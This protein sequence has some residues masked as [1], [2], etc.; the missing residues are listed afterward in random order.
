MGINSP[1]ADEVSRASGEGYAHQAYAQSL[2]EFGALRELPRCGG[3]LLER[4]VPKGTCID[5]TGCY[6]LFS[7]RNWQVLGDDL[8]AL[9]ERLV[10]AS[11]VTDPFAEITEPELRA[12]FPNVCYPYKQH[13]VTDL[14]LPLDTIVQSHHRRN[15]RKALDS[16]KVQPMLSGDELLSLWLPL[17]EN[18]VLRH[19]VRG[20]ARFSP[21]SFARQMNVPG[22]MAFAAFDG[23][24]VCG[25]TLWYLSGDVAYYHLAAYSEVGYERG[26]SF[27]LFWTALTHF[28]QLGA[29]WAALGAGAGTNASESGLTRFKQG[30]ATGTR[31]VYFCGRILQPETYQRLTGENPNMISYFPAYRCP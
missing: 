14:S 16:V 20:I 24:D 17:Y 23:D 25:M 8:E 22:F 9:S 27:A 6:P 21:Q 4:P 28:K 15:V 11:I 3:W 18:L 26:A 30:W 31:S 29:Y 1:T 10:C 5:A 12:A 7:C 2:E 19:S 13:F